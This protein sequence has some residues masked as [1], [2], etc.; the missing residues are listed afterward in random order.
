VLGRLDLPCR[1]TRLGFLETGPRFQEE[2]NVSEQLEGKTVA[3]LVADGFEQIEFTEPKK[4]LEEAG[5]TVKVVSPESGKVQGFNHF[6]M[7]DT[8]GVDV[9]LDRA[10]AEDFDALVLPGGA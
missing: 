5:A 8:F 10:K 6:D 7:A 1:P 4:A 2:T 9:P 3:I